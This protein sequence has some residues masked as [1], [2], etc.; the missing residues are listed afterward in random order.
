LQPLRQERALPAAEVAEE[1]VVR[2]ASPQPPVEAAAAGALLP[3]EAVAEALLL[4]V[5]EVAEASLP[6]LVGAV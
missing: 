2:R 5:E 3:R 6:L 1:V 4:P